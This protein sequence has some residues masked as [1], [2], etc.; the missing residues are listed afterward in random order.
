MKKKLEHKPLIVLVFLCMAVFGLIDNLKGTLLPSI[1]L[2]F[3]VDYSAIGTMLFAASL[4]YLLAS[5]VS[6]IAADRLGKKTILM[7]GFVLLI[8]ATALFYVAKSFPVTVLLLLMISTGFGC[9]EVAVNSLGAQIF[10]TNAAVMMNMT[11]LFYGLGSSISPKYAGT[12]LARSLP[13]NYIYT[14]TLAILIPGLI[15]MAFLRFP[16]TPEEESN[17]KMPAAQMLKSKKVWL[18]V[19]TL[20]FCTVAELGMANWLVN[21][22]Q[23]VRG[24]GVE[25]SSSYMTFFFA[26]FMLGRLVGGY[27]AEKIGYIRIIMYFAIISMVLFVSGMFLDNSFAFL[28][29][30]IGFFV[31]IMFPTMMSVIMKE[32]PNGT[33][34]IMGFAISAA[35]GINMIVNWIIGKTNDLLDVNYGFMSIAAYM[36]LIVVFIIPLRKMLTFDKSPDPVLADELHH[37]LTESE[38][39]GL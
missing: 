31:S 15:Y 17:N 8:G 39:A 18:I 21:F 27:I 33:S 12:M 5:L 36:L 6:G 9:V 7:F 34:S 13:W 23:E 19:A 29:S 37:G 3:G 14:I 25:Q 10:V 30:C 38:K 22:L 20:G 11:H 26:A 35:G 4:G 1:R 24:M 32:F 2:E 28:F 16:K